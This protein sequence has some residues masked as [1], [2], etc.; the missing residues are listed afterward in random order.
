MGTA[1]I[2]TTALDLI[3]WDIASS[4][5]RILLPSSQEAM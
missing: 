4:S 2:L 3:K 1:G 5:G